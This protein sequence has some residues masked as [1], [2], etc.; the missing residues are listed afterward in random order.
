MLLKVGIYDTE[1][2]FTSVVIRFLT[3]F[4][5]FKILIIV[6]RLIHHG[7]SHPRIFEPCDAVRD[8]RKPTR[9]PGAGIPHGDLRG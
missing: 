4:E 2:N 1:I 6:N 5:G 8:L 9:S 3:R 7:F